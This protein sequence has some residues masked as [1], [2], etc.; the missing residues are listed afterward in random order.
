MILSFKNKSFLFQK[1]TG[2]N[3]TVSEIEPP[4][5]IEPVKTVAPE[6]THE[7]VKNEAEINYDVEA[8]SVLTH[9]ETE[10]P[11]ILQGESSDRNTDHVDEQ[12]SQVP[13]GVPIDH[14][15]E[16]SST[17]EKAEGSQTNG[18]TGQKKRRRKGKVPEFQ[19]DNTID[20]DFAS[21]LDM[22]CIEGTAAPAVND[23]YV[24]EY[25]QYYINLDIYDY[26]TNWEYLF[27]S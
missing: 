17:P 9:V 16:Q 25:I 12:V 5:V 14:D 24:V 22:S 26:S 27:L 19:E 1:E 10:A 21:R 15:A 20:E 6:I 23:A 18:K 8:S 7:E 4:E 11:E 3:S 2:N 13:E